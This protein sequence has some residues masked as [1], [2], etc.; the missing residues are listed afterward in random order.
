M[1]ASGGVSAATARTY[2]VLNL[3]TAAFQ[4]VVDRVMSSMFERST[5]QH[6]LL[7]KNTMAREA[8]AQQAALICPRSPAVREMPVT[9]NEWRGHQVHA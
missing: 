2:H 4:P 5:V 9:Q 6:G 7:R 8:V 1:G 3:P